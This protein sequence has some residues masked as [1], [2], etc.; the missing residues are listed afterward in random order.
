MKSGGLNIGD[1]V[2]VDPQCYCS[3]T[4]VASQ[5]PVDFV[6]LEEDTLTVG[7]NALRDRQEVVGLATDGARG[8]VTDAVAR[9]G[10]GQLQPTEHQQE[11]KP[12]A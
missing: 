3:G 10:P 12:T 4:E 8:R 7:R 6:I 1:V 2:G 11:L 5:Q 9:A